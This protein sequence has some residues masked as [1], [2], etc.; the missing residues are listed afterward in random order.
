MQIHIFFSFCAYMMS[1]SPA[2]WKIVQ[3]PYHSQLSAILVFTG[4]LLCMLYHKCGYKKL[5]IQHCSSTNIFC[6]AI[7][8]NEIVRSGQEEITL[9]LFSF[10]Y[11]ERDYNNII[12][13][14]SQSGHLVH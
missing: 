10:V 11:M 12:L 13:T 14:R 4:Y 5:E 2:I 9:V 6:L 7:L 1:F 3:L 8:F